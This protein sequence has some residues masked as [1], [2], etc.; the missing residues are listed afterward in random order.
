M[1]IAPREV[2]AKLVYVSTSSVFDGTKNTPYSEGDTP[3]PQTYYGHSKYLGELATA[4]LPDFIIAR[5]CWVFG[6]GPSKDQKF[7]AKMLQ[8]MDQP[9]IRVISGK[10]GSPTYGKDVIAVVQR[11]LKEGGNG[12]YHLSNTG[13]PTRAEVVR[14]LVRITNSRAQ[15]EE[16]GAEYF[17]GTATRADNESMISQVVYTRPWQ[18][19]LEEY[20]RIEWKR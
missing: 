11:L 6:G 3:H 1:C 10:R 14:E 19:A 2:G 4:S 17:G 16:V 20:V 8:Q 12:I 18:E 7:I 13:T 15:V 9:V 5:I